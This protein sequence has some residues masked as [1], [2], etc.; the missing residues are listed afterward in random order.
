M[1]KEWTIE[2]GNS[3]LTIETGQLAQLANGSVVVRH[4]E[5]VVL[6][7]ATMDEPRS[8]ISYF[9]LMINYEERLYAAG[10]I[11]GGFIK[12]EG[13]PSDA[14]TLAARL[15]DRPLRPLFP[16]GMRH[17]VQ[18]VATVLSVD[19]DNSP[20]L[21]AMIGASAALTISD[22]PFMGPI[23]AV[24][25]GL[26][27]GEFVINPTISDSEESKLDLT[28]AGTKNAVMMVEAGADEVS[29]EKIIEAIDFGHKALAAVVELQEKMAEEIGKPKADIEL[30]KVE[31]PEIKAEVQDYVGDRL[32][33]ALQIVDKTAKNK[34]LAKVKEDIKE[35][36]AE[37]YKENEELEEIMA[38]VRQAIDKIVKQTIRT[39]VL[40]EATRI[41]GR[42]LNEVREIKSDVDLLPRTHGSGLFSRGQTQALTVATL[43]A[44]GDEQVLDGLE[45]EDSKRYMH[46][47]NFPPYS[48]GETNPLRSPGRREIGHGALGERAL[49][50]VIPGESEFPYT[51]RLVSEVLSSNGSTSQASICG[52]TLALMD[53]GVPIKAPVAGI[54]MGLMKEDEQVAILTDIQGIEDFNGDMDFKVA[55]TE[56]GITAL[57]MDVKIEGIGKEILQE[58]LQQARKGRLH[59]L[60]EMLEAISEPRENLSEYAPSIMTM[61]IDPKKIK[62]VIGRG[63]KTI[64]NIIEETGVNIDIEDDGEV[65]I[66]AEDQTSGQAAKKMIERLTKDVEVGEMYMGKVKRTTNFGAFVEILPGKEGLVHISKLADRHVK[67]VE[68]ILEEGDEVLVK[69][70]EIDDRDRINLSRKAAL[71]NEDEKENQE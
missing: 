24:K 31:R 28:V 39:L 4:G 21:A 50:P 48:V 70:I 71:D 43:G 2:F 15:I 30:K 29:E 58:A 7:T 20:D 51:I 1:K 19:P 38:A 60:D 64:K 25:V 32:K 69:V 54:A 59:I 14:A 53:A 3:D 22:I 61:Q 16:E 68:N 11:P 33:E 8:G 18:V 42:D 41:D 65:F 10:K 35:H 9:P 5:T 63:G 36:F 44:V 66:A 55:G 47:Y 46:H 13:R 34:Q 52:S 37:K 62:D 40:D 49:K 6:V 17:D 57:Q 45:E 56:T 23:G 67:K 27:E 26:V 12:R